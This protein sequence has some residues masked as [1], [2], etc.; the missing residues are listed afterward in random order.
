MWE[1]KLKEYFDLLSIS[2]IIIGFFIII[3]YSNF[4]WV[5]F[6]NYGSF[7]FGVISTVN[8]LCYLSL[9]EKDIKLEWFGGFG[10]I[11]NE[12]KKKEEY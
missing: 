8:G 9:F 10:V 4:I 6:D 3:E 7:L 12:T 1:M 5:N 11:L 2:I